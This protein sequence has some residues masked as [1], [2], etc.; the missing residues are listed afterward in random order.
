MDNS[1]RQSLIS[2]I[3]SQGVITPF[4]AIYLQYLHKQQKLAQIPDS[5]TWHNPYIA[6]EHVPELLTPYQLKQ[7]LSFQNQADSNLYDAYQWAANYLFRLD[8]HSSDLGYKGIALLGELTNMQSKN[9]LR[10]L[11]HGDGEPEIQGTLFDFSA[12]SP[13]H[14]KQMAYAEVFDAFINSFR[15]LVITIDNVLILNH[16]LH[17]VVS[18]EDLQSLQHFKLWFSEEKQQSLDEETGISLLNV[19]RLCCENILDDLIAKNHPLFIEML[20]DKLYSYKQSL[21]KDFQEGSLAYV[22]QT[23]SEITGIE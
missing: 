6:A 19:T 23:F 11:R 14:Q 1:T 16:L 21:K 8:A 22:R 17:G 13:L 20:K 4:E 18:L 3:A 5:Q 12:Y 10:F 2:K 9:A 7:M 15:F